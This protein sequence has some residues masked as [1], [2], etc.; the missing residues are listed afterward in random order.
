[1]S[2]AELVRQAQEGRG[3]AYAEL[4]RRWAGRVTALCHSRTGRA[5]VADAAGGSDSR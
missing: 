2:D 4:A 5:A 1:M 3:E